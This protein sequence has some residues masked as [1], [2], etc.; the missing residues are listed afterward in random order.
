M[1]LNAMLLSEGRDAVFSRP[2]TAWLVALIA[3]L[4]LG[5]FV[6]GHYAYEANIG[7]DESAYPAGAMLQRAVS[8]VVGPDYD[9]M[10]PGLALIALSILAAGAFAFV[11]VRGAVRA[12]RAGADVGVLA[13]AAG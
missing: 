10:G 6:A 1:L 5:W 12:E 11:L 4:A 8:A 7:L 13:R 3:A 9:W 2:R